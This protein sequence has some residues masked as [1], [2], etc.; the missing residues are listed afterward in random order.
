[1]NN[2]ENELTFRELEIIAAFSRTEHLG[3]AA[4]E[5]DCSISS[6]QRAL[7]AV[8]TRLGVTIVEREGRRLRLVQAGRVLAEHALRM[9]RNRI[10]AV[11]AVLT[12]SGRS[13]KVFRIGH[14]ITLGR[15]LAPKLVAAAV[16]RDPGLRVAL[17]TGPTS[18][19]I[20]RLLAGELD[21]ALVSPLPREADL[22]VMPLLVEPVRLAVAASDPLARLKS[23]DLGV[24]R[25]RTFVATGDGSVRHDLLNACARAGFTPKVTIEVQD[26]Y[27]LEGIV[28]AGLGVA[29]VPACMGDFPNPNVVHVPLEEKIPTQRIVGL[30]YPRDA[31]MSEPLDAILA[32]CRSIANVPKEERRSLV[33]DRVIADRYEE[34]RKFFT[35][36]T[37]NEFVPA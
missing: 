35:T 34:R 36:L 28:A 17:R 13:S 26:K 24:V 16:A 31:A 10:D 23:I 33:R 3:R 22:I 11:D 32:A 6:I 1:M 18:V 14:L 9:L 8:E 4:E 21:I 19:L 25:D 37:R 5:L 7:H 12:V 29:I 15:T 2:L 20:A 30:A 27:T